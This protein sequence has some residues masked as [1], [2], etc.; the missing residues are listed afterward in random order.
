MQVKKLIAIFSIFLIFFSLS[1][2][3]CSKNNTT[4]NE[5]S[6]PYKL[7]TF[8]AKA[9]VD[10]SGKK[11]QINISKTDK[12]S[13]ELFF[14]ST[15]K[16]KNISL[17]KTNE[18]FHILCGDLKIPTTQKDS[19]Y[20]CIFDIFELTESDIV[21]AGTKQMN[22]TVITY[23]NFNFQGQNA[24]IFFSSKT[25]LPLRIEGVLNGI[26]VIVNFLDFSAN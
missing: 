26:P 13:Y 2:S 15:D 19:I 4:Q 23:A 14:D 21:S 1:L 12:N 24:L 3:G 22:G 25:G 20:N 8:S 7:D 16:L 17:T 18:N 10:M 5:Y 6:L 9:T 11:Y